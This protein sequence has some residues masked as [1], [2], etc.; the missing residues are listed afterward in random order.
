ME[1][2]NS[3][4]DEIDAMVHRKVAGEKYAKDRMEKLSNLTTFLAKVPPIEEGEDESEVRRSMIYQ[5][6]R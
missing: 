5:R 3:L 2:F 6:T 1:D 4:G